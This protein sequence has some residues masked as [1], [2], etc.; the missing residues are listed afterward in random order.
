[1]LILPK[2]T[3]PCRMREQAAV[4]S[5]DLLVEWLIREDIKKAGCSIGYKGT[6]YLCNNQI[7]MRKITDSSLF[8]S[9]LFYIFFISKYL[10][11]KVI[12]GARLCRFVPS[13]QK[14]PSISYQYLLRYSCNSFS[15]FGAISRLIIATALWG[16]GDFR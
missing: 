5:C 2:P 9:F 1:M 16:M 12:T 4:L 7:F 6:H 3:P 15:S 13:G 10:F 11:V 8:V 14:L